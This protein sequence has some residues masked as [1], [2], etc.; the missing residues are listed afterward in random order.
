M[1][2]FSTGNV[3]LLKQHR[4]GLW[5]DKQR[6]P[7]YHSLHLPH[8]TLWNPT[9]HSGLI[10]SIYNFDRV[11][12]G[13][14]ARFFSILMADIRLWKEHRLKLLRDVLTEFDFYSFLPL[15]WPRSFTGT[16]LRD[17][18]ESGACIVREKLMETF[19]RDCSAFEG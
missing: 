16:S 3:R 2:G 11:D 17:P 14:G 8:V 13:S 5:R 6:Y 19:R 18:A 9:E 1:R 4:F 7:A 15:N 12:A 10:T